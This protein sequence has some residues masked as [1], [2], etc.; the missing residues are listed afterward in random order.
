M[1]CTIA[2]RCGKVIPVTE[3][4]AG[5]SLSCECG[6]T[7]VV[8]ALS[9]LRAHASDYGAPP[10]DQDAPASSEPKP[11][12]RL[13]PEIMAPASVLVRTE[14]AAGSD[15]P[16]ARM[17]A[18]T[19]DA[20]W[21]QD[22]WRVRC[23][24]LQDFTIDRGFRA[25]ELVLT[26]NGPETP[27]E[28]LVLKFASAGE[29]QRWFDKVQ[30]W[31]A[32][33][34]SDAPPIRRTI[35]DGIALVC[36]APDVPH[37]ELGRVSCTQRT[38]TT[39]DGGAQ[40][41]AAMRG[42]DAIIDLNREKCP[43]IGSNAR[44]VSG[45]AIRVEDSDSRN[46]L[47]WA[48][49]AEECRALLIRMLILV[50]VEGAL[51][52]V[53][54]A[55][56]PGKSG[57]MAATGETASESLVSAGLGVG[58]IFFWPLLLI[59]LLWC[60]RW[61]ELIRPTGIAV[62]CVSTLRGL[63]VAAAHLLAVLFTGASL[64]E[65]KIWMLADPFDWAFII[66]GAVLCVRA[67]RLGARARQIL[68]EESLAASAP[69]KLCSRAVVAAT[70]ILAVVL[71]GWVGFTRYDESRHLLHPGVDPR[72]EQEALVAL[73]TGSELANKGNL[74]AAD[75]AFQRSLR[76]WESLASGPSAPSIYRI[77][78]AVTL[79]DLGW[80]RQKQGRSDEAEAYYSRTVALADQ[81][82][83]DAQLDE[84]TKETFSGARVALDD[85]RDR[86]NFKV[87][88]EKDAEADRKSE[89]AEIRDDKGEAEAESL[90]RETI[91]LWEEILPK[92]TNEAYKKSTVARLAF[93]YLRVGEMQSQDG[94]RAA[95]EASLK[96]AIEYGEKAVALDPS[97]PL[98]KH[99]V[100]VA[101]RALE[102]LREQEFL[103]EI[104][105]LEKA[106]R[107][108]EVAAIY[109]RGVDEHERRLQSGKDT[110]LAISSLA[111]RLQRYAWFLAHCPDDSV[112]NTKAAVSH[113]RRAA[114]LRSDVADYW[115]TLAMVQYRNSDWRESLESLEKAKVVE[116][117]SDARHWLVSA[118]DL[119]HLNRQT[120]ARAAIR[121]ASDWI[122]ERTGS[123]ATARLRI[124][125]ELLRPAIESL[126]REVRHLFGDDVRV[127]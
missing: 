79:Y 74:A 30:E 51:L 7:V 85:L 87:L 104:A 9:Q 12:Q 47:R 53:A 27:R 100:A 44:R 43:E 39:S 118:L 99:N 81:V 61:P 63:I 50:L 77:N 55:Y 33:A 18:L 65:S 62:L 70:G 89:E 2:C 88:N 41:R 116:G 97:R 13:L 76:I 60:L 110:E 106:E 45:L 114:E 68:P 93:A 69:R 4:M 35:P 78:L 92:A 15:R 123:A 107:F 40:L 67:W 115:Y 49:Y 23:L 31:Q 91:A 46:R 111:Y 71:V 57:L 58:M 5:V 21:I 1:E 28:K 54:A 52:F 113:A 38:P 122:D 84:E 98:P 102:Q 94:K 14:C 121:K 117:E 83:D 64:A 48:W 101:R 56:L 119:Y 8:P 126:L 125:Y 127:G 10:P 109:T 72:R 26:L 73:N 86:K 90:Y 66:I 3:G 17:I 32:K 34:S 22:T 36:N 108:A 19:S 112:R 24:A 120:D 124:E 42:A 96:K 29:V 105:K 6:A 80:I 59:A 25:K 16:A 82:G 95:A 11:E 75:A 103:A 37:V 20:L